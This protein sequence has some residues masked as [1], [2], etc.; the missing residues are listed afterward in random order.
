MF[1]LFKMLV[2]FFSGRTM[3]IVLPPSTAPDASHEWSELQQRCLS[4]KTGYLA[5][6]K[7]AYLSEGVRISIS[8]AEAH[9][10]QPVRAS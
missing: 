10:S 3:A 4:G 1:N 5:S 8:P 7:S 6:L 9:M 2:A